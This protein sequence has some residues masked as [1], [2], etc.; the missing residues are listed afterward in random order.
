[1]VWIDIKRIRIPCEA[2][3]CKP[4]SEKLCVV[5]STSRSIM[6]PRYFRLKI[7]R[8]LHWWSQ[9]L[10]HTH[11]RS[12]I[13][14]HPPISRKCHWV[15]HRP[16][17][18]VGAIKCPNR[19]DL[20]LLSIIGDKFIFLIV[21]WTNTKQHLWST[22]LDPAEQ[23]KVIC[24]TSGLPWRARRREKRMQINLP[25]REKVLDSLQCVPLSL[26]WLVHCVCWVTIVGLVGWVCR[27]VVSILVYLT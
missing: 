6:W 17:S 1:M 27:W 5:W 2:I 23:Y 19:V 18:L 14:N 12:R 21:F 24:Q 15:K 26:H 4:V 16:L 3:P 8:H 13:Y 10:G 25:W 7:N 9:E 11:H 22:M 20:I